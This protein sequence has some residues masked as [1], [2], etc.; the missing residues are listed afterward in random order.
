LDSTDSWKSVGESL[1]G[2]VKDRECLDQRNMSA[3][4]AVSQRRIMK[5]VVSALYMH[6]IGIRS[7][8]G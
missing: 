4:Q 3:S 2:F 5:F 7:Q 6:P 8:A 1:L